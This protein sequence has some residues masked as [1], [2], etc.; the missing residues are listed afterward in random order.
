M[1]LSG[2]LAV[3]RGKKIRNTCD[4]RLSLVQALR[5]RGLPGIAPRFFGQLSRCVFGPP[6]PLFISAQ[7][8]VPL[9]WFLL[10][11]FFFGILRIT[12]RRFL[13]L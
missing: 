6:D 8:S 9:G 7:P 12:P 13:F 2:K 5:M 10:F 4:H 3:L 1:R 11:P